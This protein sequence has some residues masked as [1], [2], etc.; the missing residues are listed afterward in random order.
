MTLTH[1]CNLIEN[2]L[3]VVKV[4]M[5]NTFKLLPKLKYK[6]IMHNQ[7]CGC[8][9]TLFNNFWSYNKA[10]YQYSYF[11]LLILQTLIIKKIGIFDKH[12]GFQMY[13]KTSTKWQIRASRKQV[14]NLLMSKTQF[15]VSLPYRKIRLFSN[16]L[17]MCSTI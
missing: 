3:N 7:C 11:I 16:K 10:E 9:R 5:K 13:P 1:W 15:D 14:K 12:Y 8:F 17:W 4:S 2:W 6:R